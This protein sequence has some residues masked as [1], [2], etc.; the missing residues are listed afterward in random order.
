[1][2]SLSGTREAV[3]GSDSAIMDS[4][5]IASIYDEIWEFFVWH[6]LLSIGKKKRKKEKKWSKNL[7]KN[8]F[9]KYENFDFC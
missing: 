4:E 5:L 1:M 3:P 7:K 6:F 2:S 8:F 9:F